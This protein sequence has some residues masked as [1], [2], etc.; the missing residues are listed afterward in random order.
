M[1]MYTHT[2][3]SL[4]G[5]KYLSVVTD[6]GKHTTRLYSRYLMEQ[7][8]GR[9]LSRSEH[10]D[11]IDGDHTNDALENLQVLSASAHGKKTAQQLGRAPE[12][13]HGVCPVCTAAFT[14]PAK[15]VRANRKKG[16]AGPYCSRRCAGVAHT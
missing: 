10:V 7:Q 2:T 5:R 3:G 15:D 6:D 8:L 16:K 4:K 12:M 11:H 1:L 13:Y 9:K 14:K